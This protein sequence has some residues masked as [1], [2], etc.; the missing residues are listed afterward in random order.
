MHA[1]TLKYISAEIQKCT[2]EGANGKAFG[3][4]QANCNQIS[5][6]NGGQAAINA[7]LATS[8]DKNPYDTTAK[9]VVDSN[10]Y[11]QGQVSV[12]ASGKEIT[13][14]SCYVTTCSNDNIS[15]EAKVTIE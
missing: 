4:T 1:Q 3:A 6:N 7:L 13:I 10:A 12:K 9:A 14:K 15:G 8:K 5:G 11:V 2:L